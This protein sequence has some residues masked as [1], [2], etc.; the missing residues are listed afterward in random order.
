MTDLIDY[1]PNGTFVVEKFGK[2][3]C[4]ATCRED[5]CHGYKCCGWAGYK[6]GNQYR[7]ACV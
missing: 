7:E 6:E 1:C 5:C 2:I 4:R 3:V